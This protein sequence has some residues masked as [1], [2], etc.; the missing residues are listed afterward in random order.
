MNTLEKHLENEENKL[1]FETTQKSMY[2]Y[3]TEK[4]LNEQANDMLVDFDEIK[5]EPKPEPNNN[6]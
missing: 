5:P 2:D 6:H 4:E 3:L 1:W